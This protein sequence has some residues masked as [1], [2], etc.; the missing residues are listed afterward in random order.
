MTKW[1][2]LGVLA[3][4]VLVVLSVT[5]STY[6]NLVRQENGI[7]AVD[8]DMQNVHASIYKQMK[9]QGLAVEKYGDMVIKALDAAMS[10]RYGEGGSRAAFQWIH[11]QNP[12]IA[13]DIMTK[14]QQVI[15][16][17]YNRF[18]ATQRAKIDKV[19]VYKDIL[20]FFPSNMI[21]GMLGFPKI[22][23]SMADRVI[24]SATTKKDFESGELSDPDPFSSPAAQPS[25]P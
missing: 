4:L 1:I 21:A 15:E 23:M 18:E 20:R 12:N 22:D 16:A 2:V 7:D 13:P 5:I 17:G 19:R 24:S 3:L 11:E 8:K 10:G 14:L 6:N 25:T 9:G